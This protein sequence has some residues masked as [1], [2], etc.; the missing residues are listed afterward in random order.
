MFR[1]CY[2]NAHAIYRPAWTHQYHTR[3]KPPVSPMDV[4]FLVPEA[5]ELSNP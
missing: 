3:H 4:A 2:Y 1:P 5:C